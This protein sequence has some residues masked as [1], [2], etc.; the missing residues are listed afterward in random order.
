VSLVSAS[1]IHAWS[2]ADWVMLAILGT[3]IA[4][5]IWSVIRRIAARR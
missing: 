4:A 3:L 2:P 5:G 1:L